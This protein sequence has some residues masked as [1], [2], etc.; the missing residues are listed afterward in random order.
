VEVAFQYRTL[1]HDQLWNLPSPYRPGTAKQYSDI[2]DWLDELRG[3]HFGASRRVAHNGDDEVRK[4]EG[5]A[6]G[7][8]RLQLLLHFLSEGQSYSLANLSVRVAQA[9]DKSREVLYR[10]LYGDEEMHR[11]NHSGP[12][13]LPSKLSTKGDSGEKKPPIVGGF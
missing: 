11:S 3:L 13:W 5:A 4:E 1:R 8:N 10:K 9:Q 6:E 7:W 12:N 2:L